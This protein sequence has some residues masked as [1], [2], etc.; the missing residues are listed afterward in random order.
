MN[1]R[2]TIAGLLLLLVSLSSNARSIEEVTQQL[3]EQKLVRGEFSQ[4]RDM[5][6]FSQPLT[7]LG[8]FVIDKK[9]GLLWQQTTPFPVVLVLSDHKLSQKF[10]EQSPQI[11]TA[12][13]NPMVFYFSHIFLS[14]F[15]GDT[16]QLDKQFTQSFSELADSWK[17]TLKP[18]QAPLDAVFEQIVITG[19][20]YIDQIELKEVRGDNTTIRFSNQTEYPKNLTAD[21]HNLFDF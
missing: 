8:H 3:S 4:Q 9:S 15:D 13:E 18:K 17:L 7:S 10:G 21:E 11:M 19:T 16:K 20:R 5:E 6:M 2:V 14:L 1:R 12:E